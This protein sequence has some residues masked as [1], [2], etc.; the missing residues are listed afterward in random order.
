MFTRKTSHVWIGILVLSCMFLMGQEP[1]W[2]PPDPCSSIPCGPNEICVEGTCVPCI[3]ISG[4]VQTN[5]VGLKGVKISASGPPDFEG[6]AYTG[7]DGT[8]SVCVLLPGEYTVTVSEWGYTFLEGMKVVNVPESQQEVTGVDFEAISSSVPS[9]G[10]K[11]RDVFPIGF[12]IQSQDVA[13]APEV[14]TQH[15]SMV[16]VQLYFR[17]IHPEEN[18]YNFATADQLIEFANSNGIPVRGHSLI[19][20]NASVNYA[21]WLWVDENGMDATRELMIERMRNHIYTVVGRYKGKVACWDVVN[22]AINDFTAY[23]PP[24]NRWSELLGEDYVEL[25][26][27][28]AHEADPDALLF[29]NDYNLDWYPSK[30]TLGYNL[31]QD[32]LQRNVPVHGIGF[33]GRWMHGISTISGFVDTID[34]FSSLGL[35]VQITEQDMSV[36]SA[37]A[38][39][40]PFL[41]P[42]VETFTDEMAHRQAETYDTLFSA[43]RSRKDSITGVIFWGISDDTS[44]LRSY[45]G[46]RLDWPLLFDGNYEPK[47]AFWAVANF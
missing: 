41:F 31:L 19:G 10:E 20:G 9:L 23:G 38:F 44:W 2:P 42:P 27:Q 12:L 1:Y 28:F 35:Q 16:T 22:E 5:G 11:Y 36:Y 40:L 43:L 30:R 37:L 18:T 14:I 4:T 33:Q 7:D 26:F 15:A 8:Y 34:L 24:L 39:Y 3:Y 21:D 25:A 6:I 29:Y 32:L 13:N 46:T 45:F 17:N 47:H